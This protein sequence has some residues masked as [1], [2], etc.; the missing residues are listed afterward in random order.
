[1][2]GV[3]F[4]KKRMIVP[5]FLLL[6]IM[7]VLTISATAADSDFT[8]SNGELR[9]YTG[10]GGDVM[11][12]D[13]VTRI[14]QDAF[15][16]CTSL[17]SV[18]IPDSVTWI[19]QNAFSGCTSLT[20]VTI[21]NSV[22]TIYYFAFENCTSLT[23]VIIPD[24]VTT[25]AN[26]AFRGCSGL[27]SV[28]ISGSVRWIGDS[29]FD[30]C[31]G[32]TSVTIPDSVTGI[33][34]CAFRHCTSLTS[35]T[36][37]NG[38]TSIGYSAFDGCSSLTSVIIPDSVT[39][40]GYSAFGG[41]S[42]L[43][44]ATIP[45]SV[46]SIGYGAFGGCSSLTSVTIPD[47]V[48]SIESGVFDGCSSLTSI[49]IPD[50]VISIGN[51][52]FRNCTS[53][54]S[55]TIPNSVTNIEGNYDF[56]RDGA[57][58]GCSGL[59][60][61]TIGNSVTNIGDCAFR[62]C[63]KLTSVTI[64]DSVT[65]IG[66]GAFDHCTSLTSVSIPDSVIKIGDWTFS[67]C[68]ELT[69][70]TIPD[71]VTSIGSG[72]F[73]NCRKL[74]SVTVPDSV[75]SIGQHVFSGCDS[76]IEVI[77]GDGVTSLDSFSF[78][79]YKQ[80]KKVIIGKS[81]TSIGYAFR[82]CSNLTSVTIPDSVTSIGAY[83][84]SGCTSL[85][86]VTI[87]DSVTSIGDYAFFK[88]SALTSITIPDSV[89]SIKACAFNACSVL[90]DVYY[91]GNEEQWRAISISSGNAPLTSEIMHYNSTP[92]DKPDEPDNPVKSK[93]AIYFTPSNI[94]NRYSLLFSATVTAV[95]PDADSYGAGDIQWTS[96]IDG[97]SSTPAA[98][99]VSYENDGTTLRT[100]LTVTSP[101]TYSVSTP[102]GRSASFTAVR[103]E[104][105]QDNPDGINPVSPKGDPHRFYIGG[106]A[107]DFLVNKKSELSAV[108]YSE[109][110]TFPEGGVVSVEWV[111]SDGGVLAFEKKGL[112]SVSHAKD[113][114]TVEK[115]LSYGSIDD[116]K[117]YGLSEG[118]VTVTCTVKV[119]DKTF[120]D[121]ATI[122]VYSK[123]SFNLIECCRQWVSAYETYMQEVEN[124]LQTYTGTGDEQVT[125]REQA[126]RLMKADQAS[127]DKLVTFEV[128]VN[129]NIK[130]D[131]YYAVAEY[132]AQRTK[133]N[134]DFDKIN[135]EGVDVTSIS[136]SIVHKVRSMVNSVSYTCKLDSA[137][138]NMGGDMGGFG[139]I[140]SYLPISY[141]DYT[142]NKGAVKVATLIT[143][144]D[145]MQKTIAAFVENLLGLENN[146]V[147][148]A[149]K[150]IAKE[151][152]GKSLSGLIDEKVKNTL[153]KNL[154]KHTA[155]FKQA[156][157]GD[158]ADGIGN[159]I[160]Y[161]G[162]VKKLMELGKAS[163]DKLVTALASPQTFEFKTD[164]I[165][166]R[167]VAK[168]MKGI[169]KAQTKLDKKLKELTDGS[170]V[171]EV[172]YELCHNI[173]KCPV[174][175][176]IQLENIYQ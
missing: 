101:G 123:E 132:L 115:L 88:C 7:E 80:L 43:T 109:D 141:N 175:I 161:Y 122:T 8:I 157:V 44:N 86:S 25:I 174:N 90:K 125:I 94:G 114:K 131:V 78:S 46:T 136:A 167:V 148:Q 124:A 105:K 119:G 75:T 21:P 171:G 172:A 38:V 102:D 51:R 140:A 142:D 58:T 20:S 165:E 35:V 103:I 72:A 150:E 77:I 96:I 158:L 116:V 47:S 63:S 22:T 54:T 121:E 92:P 154:Q 49:T 143:T 24:S 120:T 68:S 42:S 45:N 85:T 12:P 74:T 11:I 40:I 39:S 66:S 162:H 163:P 164:T 57:F 34:S 129:E 156:G 173:F 81:I 146:L 37:P 113:G 106:A 100:T 3:G 155:V 138:V 56:G 36:I 99:A 28:T 147:H 23:S 4:V 144:Q 5:V 98:S 135:L 16:S 67:G 139:G 159:C 133:V 15:S 73:Q 52:A 18:T 79:N 10:S 19:G 6:L 64:P 83:A 59:T 50:S 17:T 149:Y 48:T 31:I 145:E 137:E 130:K 151:V 160:G 69:D 126:E 65:S 117:V 152:F 176:V 108:F 111:S 168:A 127:N 71:S 14:G 93:G 84:F 166:N 60:S 170:A 70:V 32:L 118:T 153:L 61:V 110:S 27:T 89:T 30:G 1:M 62:N 29:T 134:F 169:K 33:G 95:I 112:S 91:T 13:S 55:V 53:L 107:N 97:V 9:K 41:C 76:L 82:D 128:A 104:A 2:K 26:L 87:P